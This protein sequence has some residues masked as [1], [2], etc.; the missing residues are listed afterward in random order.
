MNQRSKDL[1]PEQDSNC[2][3][4]PDTSHKLNAQ[5]SAS[6]ALDIIQDSASQV[7]D[8]FIYEFVYSYPPRAALGS[9]TCSADGEQKVQDSRTA[10]PTNLFEPARLV[11]GE[12]ANDAAS[13]ALYV[14]YPFCKQKCLYCHYCT[15]AK[16]GAQDLAETYL[17]G[18]LEEIGAFRMKFQNDHRKVTS[19][20]LG[21][22]TPTMMRAD[23][24]KSLLDGIGRA[25]TR[26]PGSEITSEC[27]PA[28]AERDNL[29]ELQREGV[30]RL[31]I[32]VQTFDDTLLRVLKPGCSESTVLRTL[33][34]ARSAGFELV[35]ID[36]I[37]GLPNDPDQKRDW[38]RSWEYTLERTCELM[39]SSVSLY[40][41]RVKKN[42]Q[43]AD[44]DAARFP[45][46]R[47][48][49][50]MAMLARKVLKNIGYV[51]VS[52]DF[53]LLDELYEPGRPF[54]RYQGQRAGN[55]PFIGF[56]VSAYSFY[57]G[58]FYYNTSSIDEYLG[59][60]VPSYR[61]GASKPGLPIAFASVLAEDDLWRR[62][63]ILA[64]RY[65]SGVDMKEC[66]QRYGKEACGKLNEVVRP[67]VA[68]NLMTKSNDFYFLEDSGRLLVDEICTLF[69]GD[70][71]RE[72]LRKKNRRY[73]ANAVPGKGE[74]A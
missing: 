50:Q 43:I 55:K 48:T 38:F 41:L 13:L 61:E 33:E 69:Y 24:I 68:A 10:A 66:R 28:T 7:R 32:G 60:L 8:R 23:E 20:F 35:N 4:V 49:L 44:F 3:R 2:A 19:I 51:E 45:E 42:A 46:T 59:I 22:G 17:R 40:Q 70:E 14:H 39:P 34:Y 29:R 56:G 64:L 15:M 5:T 72:A 54:S 71:V 25:F 26:E 37:Y 62:F 21:G 1:R 53:Y 73:G 47:T 30:N 58:A 57:N 63:A 31:S 52:P 18:L 16:E 11:P 27:E 12:S 9:V 36:L 6:S 67:L 74:E 65:G